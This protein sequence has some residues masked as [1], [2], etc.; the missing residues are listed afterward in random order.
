MESLNKIKAGLSLASSA[1]MELTGE[2]NGIQYISDS[3]SVNM[4][5]TVESVN[6]IA[7]DM[8]LIIGGNDSATDYSFL[9]NA[10]LQKVKAV[11][12]LGKEPKRLLDVILKNKVLFLTAISFEEAVSICK[13]YAQAG[14]VVLFSPA[15]SGHDSENFKSAVKQNN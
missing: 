13:V 9:A 7:A 1:Q 5:S 14:Q 4:R 11:I 3:K 10:E 12:Y 6:S 15:C 8:L 2:I